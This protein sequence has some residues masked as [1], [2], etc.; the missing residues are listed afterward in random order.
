M[1]NETKICKYCQTEIPKKAKVCPQCRKKQGNAAGA[2][3][4][5]LGV[6][7]FLLGFISSLGESETPS[8]SNPQNV[9]N[10]GSQQQNN[11]SESPSNE[12]KVGDIVETSNYKISFLSSSEWASDNQYIT[13]K[14]G[15]V[16]YRFEFEFENISDNDQ[17]VSASDFNCYADDYASEMNFYGDDALSIS[18]LSKG[19]KIKG[20][21]YFEV[22]ADAENIVLEYTTN[23]W[24]ENKII[25]NI[26]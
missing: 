9:G 20:A 4:V 11:N 1:K 6:T 22:P 13:P 21:I 16:F 3:L 26:K 7:F 19:K 8:D 2:V 25:F 23:F 18:T 14:D 15:Y 10:V 5:I 17:Y 12:F 24:T